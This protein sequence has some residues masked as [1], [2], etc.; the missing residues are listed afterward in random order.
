MFFPSLCISSCLLALLEFF[1]LP[2][3][4]NGVW[5]G[6][7]RNKSFHLHVAL[8]NGVLSR[9]Q[10]ANKTIAYW[11]SE[12][13]LACLADIIGH[14]LDLAREGSFKC[15]KR[16]QR[17]KMGKL[18]RLWFLLLSSRWCPSIIVFVQK[19]LLV[20][21]LGLRRDGSVTCLATQARG[22]KS[23]YQAPRCKLV[24]QHTCSSGLREPE[25]G[26]S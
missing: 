14:F 8:G 10:K 4:V 5:P 20:D 25:T 23:R 1:P 6:Y 3:L 7:V 24:W 12:G 22:P 2:P 15:F 17:S 11:V 13:P 26:R 21:Y 19:N 16:K 18:H 9:Q